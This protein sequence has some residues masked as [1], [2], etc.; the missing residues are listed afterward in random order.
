MIDWFLHKIGWRKPYVR[1]LEICLI[2]NKHWCGNPVNVRKQSRMARW[3][4]ENNP[5][6]KVAIH[7]FRYGDMIAGFRFDIVVL[8]TPAETPEEL[9]YIR[10]YVFPRVKRDGIVFGDGK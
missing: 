10:H 4:T 9:E 5:N 8:C 7:V 1:P 3:W 6:R 2:G